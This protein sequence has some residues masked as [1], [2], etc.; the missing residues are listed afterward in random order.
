VRVHGPQLIRQNLHD[1]ECVCR[2]LREVFIILVEHADQ[3]SDVFDA[4]P[5]DD[6]EFREL[7]PKR[8]R[9]GRPLID[10]QLPGRMLHQRR[11]LLFALYANKPHVR[12]RR[13]FADRACVMR[14][15]LPALE[16]RLYIVRGDQAYPMA[17]TADLAAP[18]MG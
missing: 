16:V 17:Q 8:V 15:G 14:V 13:G 9:N 11:L 5:L 1:H 4:L 3:L 2:D 7:T 10:E 12:P 18:I 6:A